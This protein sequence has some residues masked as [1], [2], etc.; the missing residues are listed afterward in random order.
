MKHQVL[1][2]ERLPMEGFQDLQ[3]GYLM[4]FP[5]QER[6]FS[7]EE[8][9]EKITACDALIST[10]GFPVDGPLIEKARRLKIISN[11]GVGYNN[12]DIGAATRK[13]VLVTNTPVS[14]VEPT[15]ELA[16]G[17]LIGLVRRIGEM[18]R[19]LRRRDPVKWAMMENLGASLIGKNL[20]IFG[21]GNIGK[22]FAKR[23]LAS[24]MN[25]YYH[26][27]NRLS[28]GLEK[29]YSAQYLSKEELCQKADIISLNTPLSSETHHY[30]SEK[31]F[32]AMKDGVFIINTARGA[33]M[34]EQ[35]LIKYLKAGKVAGAGLDVFEQEPLIPDELLDMEQ[36]VLTPH[37]GT[38]AYDI[39][40]AMCQEVS[41]NIQACFQGK[42][43]P[44][45]VNT[46]VFSTKA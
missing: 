2:V 18:D 26:N 32:E 44:A 14:V 22:A 33:V 24:G 28:P 9:E 45:L 25:I 6:N 37:I 10:V 21:L 38:A 39:R 31:E 46:E 1:I 11:Y 30:I 5:A 23:A 35:H 29:E 7:R 13:G 20:G 17:L 4:H 27:R 42:K 43:P 16:F 12:I 36:V 34:D 19:R 8:V 40:V 41:R 15:A 3:D